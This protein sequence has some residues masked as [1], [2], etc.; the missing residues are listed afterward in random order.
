M[1]IVS[2][3]KGLN[4]GRLLGTDK[5]FGAFV[6]WILSPKGLS[7]VPTDAGTLVKYS[8]LVSGRQSLFPV[9][10]WCRYTS[11]EEVRRADCAFEAGIQ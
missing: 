8:T 10:D 6:A 4:P 1:H 3:E 9:P 7:L 2:N 5:T 11:G